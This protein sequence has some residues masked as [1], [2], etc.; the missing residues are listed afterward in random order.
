[1]KMLTHRIRVPGC[2]LYVG[3]G[4]AVTGGMFVCLSNNNSLSRY[5]C[6]DAW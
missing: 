1:M 4:E 6:M 3:G 2:D 5:S